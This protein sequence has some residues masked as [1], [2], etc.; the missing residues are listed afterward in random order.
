VT[1]QGG[2]LFD[3]KSNCGPGGK[4]R[5]LTTGFMTIVTCGLTQAAKKS[6]PAVSPLFII[7]CGTTVNTRLLPLQYLAV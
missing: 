3:W 7:E 1:G 5:E 2:D 4:Y 6:G